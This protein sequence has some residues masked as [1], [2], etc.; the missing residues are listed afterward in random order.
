MNTPLATVRRHH[1]SPSP[2]S[3]HVRYVDVM[4][5][6]D[7]SPHADLDAAVQ[8]VWAA[9]GEDALH[10]AYERFGS[11]VFTYCVRSLGNRDDA[12]EVTQDTFVS[13]WR[14]RERFDPDKGSLAAWLLGIAR[15]RVLDQQ[16]R[17]LRSVSAEA[18]A[19]DAVQGDEHTD[20]IAH[21]LLIARALEALPE[22]VRKVV[23][24]AFWSEYSHSEIA[25]RLGVPLGTVK[26]DVRRA[27]IHLRSALGGEFDE[28]N[29]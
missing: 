27:L 26:S 6:V 1:L 2:N 5:A 7:P 3:S 29:A 28:R 25:D 4:R 14:S 8:T 23:E 17:T 10:L 18:P 19:A 9:G 22:R 24:L 12:A 16:R 13:A 15:F 20:A 11:L 21:Q